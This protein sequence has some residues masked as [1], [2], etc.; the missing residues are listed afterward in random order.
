MSFK[1]EHEKFTV[2]KIANKVNQ[3]GIGKGG[4]KIVLATT[5]KVS[6]HKLNFKVLSYG[7]R[8]GKVI[9]YSQKESYILSIKN[10]SLTVY[11]RT[12]NEDGLVRLRNVSTSPQLFSYLGL[13][14]KTH[15]KR[16]SRVINHFFIKNKFPR[17][18]KIKDGKNNLMECIYPALKNLDGHTVVDSS[19]SRFLRKNVGLK[20]IIKKTFGSKG[21]KLT[22]TVL[23]YIEERKCLNV[24]RAG[25]VT[26]GLL[27]LDWVIDNLSKEVWSRIKNASNFRRFLKTFSEEGRKR[28]LGSLET[29]INSSRVI[30]TGI[31]VIRSDTV[32]LWTL[33]N[34]P[35]IPKD[36]KDWQE[37]H[38][39]LAKEHR[40]IRN[41]DKE[42][43]YSENVLKIDSARIGDLTIELPK[44]SHKLIEYSQKMNNCI[45]S[46]ADRAVGGQ[47]IL[48]GIYKNDELAYNV[49]IRNQEIV[50]FVGKHNSPAPQEDKD[51]IK[52]FLGDEDVLKWK[53]FN[54]TL[55]THYPAEL[56]AF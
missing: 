13:D 25:V 5:W 50:Q 34:R 37:I 16:I 6:P 12:I 38:D 31:D 55:P 29:E 26:K 23:K 1:K 2:W 24:F 36:L 27:P 48:L 22:K 17:R 49:E 44:S 18:L 42:I 3:Y 11:R 8:E 46:Y 20:E 10:G 52:K 41:K 47:V 33:L 21:S 35:Q 7:K 32:E 45:S 54:P 43:K 14:A 9:H 19:F 4:G 53:E 51:A 28:L 30:R 56:V 39:Y 40:K 15:Y